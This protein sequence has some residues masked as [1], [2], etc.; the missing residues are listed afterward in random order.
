MSS[1]SYND[2]ANEGFWET[3]NIET[4]ARSH[5]KVNQ[6]PPFQLKPWTPANVLPEGRIVELPMRK[7]IWYRRL[8]DWNGWKTKTELWQVVETSVSDDPM[9]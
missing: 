7:P 5:C 1:K 3:I 6:P 2:Y 8:F 4:G 9:V